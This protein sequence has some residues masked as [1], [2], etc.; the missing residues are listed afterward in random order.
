MA[1]DWGRYHDLLDKMDRVGLTCAETTEY[2]AYMPEVNR[3]DADEERISAPGLA[4]LD[5]AH[6]EVIASIRRLTAAIREKVN[7]D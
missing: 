4:K 6:D 5:R 1:I 2:L 3:L 7:A